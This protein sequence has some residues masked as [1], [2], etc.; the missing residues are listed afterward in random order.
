M[1]DIQFLAIKEFENK[2]RTVTGTRIN[3]GDIITI[4]ASAGKDMYLASA[5]INWVR[6]ASTNPTIMKVELVVNGLLKED[7]QV[8]AN[9]GVAQHAISSYEFL[10]KG[11]KVTAGQ[12]IRLDFITVP[13]SITMKA[14]LE[15]WEEDS[16]TSPQIPPLEPV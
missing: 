9:D 10:L 16:G 6:Q 4:S 14:V 13:T 11:L 1:G 8:A 3:A 2:L 7:Y 5:K 12:I 15:V